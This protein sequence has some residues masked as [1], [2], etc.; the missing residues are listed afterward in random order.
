MTRLCRNPASATIP[1]IVSLAHC[2][3]VIVHCGNLAYTVPDASATRPRHW[4]DIWTNWSLNSNLPQPNSKPS[5]S[6]PPT[7]RMSET[8]RR[9][10]SLSVSIKYSILSKS[11]RQLPANKC[12]RYCQWASALSNVTFLHYK[13]TAFWSEK[14]RIMVGFEK[15]AVAQ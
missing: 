14:V 13:R 15:V 11:L 8:W 2:L 3:P 10:N 12:R 6:P 5:S 7:P 4:M 9:R 1:P